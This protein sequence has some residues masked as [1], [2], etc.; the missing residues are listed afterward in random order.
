MIVAGLLFGLVGADK[1][2]GGGRFTL[3]FPE[4]AGGL[5]FVAVAIGVFGVAEI[6]ERP[7]ILSGDDFTVRGGSAD[8]SIKAKRNASENMAFEL[9][10]PHIRLIDGIAT[11]ET[12]IL[13]TSYR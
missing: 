13:L 12:S 5:S 2:A 6:D 11:T 4:L 3:G 1:F 10:L 7:V 9:Q 8:A